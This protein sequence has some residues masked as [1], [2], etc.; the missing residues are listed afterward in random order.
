MALEVD[1][2]RAW[3][4]ELHQVEAASVLS[5]AEFDYEFIDLAFRIDSEFGDIE[6]YE[7][8][9]RLPARLYRGLKD[10]Y[11]EQAEQIENAVAELSSHTKG[12]Y[13]RAT[14]WSLR[15]PKLEEV[16]TAPSVDELFENSGLY[17]VQRLWTKAKARI[18]NDP[19]G[20]ITASRTMLESLCKI[21]ISEQGGSYTNTDELPILYKKAVSAIRLAPGSMTEE[22][23]KKLG[24]ACS[25]VVNSLSCIRNRE[26][27]SHVAVQTAT[28]VHAKFAVN[29]S[30]SLAT[31]LIGIRNEKKAKR[32]TQTLAAS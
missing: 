28:Q 2:V 3:L 26:G 1:D 29:L 11:K 18:Q 32:A 15:I 27:D 14:H 5:E 23:Y 17:D 12:C 30:G 20:A 13:I 22:E 9:I 31:F 19:D 16:E 4:L 21:M 25:T 7:L 24:G 8:T 10:R 6:I